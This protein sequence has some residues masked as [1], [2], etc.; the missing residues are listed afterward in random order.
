MFIQLPATVNSSDVV[1]FL[2]E[3]H[4]ILVLDGKR[5][6]VGNQEESNGVEN[7]IRISIAYPEVD[8]MKHAISTICTTLDQLCK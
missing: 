5:F 1:A 2:R 6:L 4:D 3:K 8:N 7:G